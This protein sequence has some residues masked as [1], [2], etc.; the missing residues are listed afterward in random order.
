MDYNLKAKGFCECK[1]CGYQ[2]NLENEVI[3]E[4]ATLCGLA[5]A[6]NGYKDAEAEIVWEC[7]GCGH[8]NKDIKPVIIGLKKK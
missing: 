1:K 6:S 3:S 5:D 4:K 8:K 7:P 2:Y